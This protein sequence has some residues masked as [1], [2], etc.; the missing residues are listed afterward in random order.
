M[1]ESIV[2]PNT[3]TMTLHSKNLSHRSLL[4]VSEHCSITKQEERTDVITT[5]MVQSNMRVLGLGG[6]LEAFGASKFKENLARS[7]QALLYIMERLPAPPT[8]RL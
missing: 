6:R 4:M 1:E 5:Q 8:R 3:G 2:D 7:R